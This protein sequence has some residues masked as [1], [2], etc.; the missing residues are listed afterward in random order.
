MQKEKSLVNA[1]VIKSNAYKKTSVKTAKGGDVIEPP[2]DIEELANLYTYNGFHQKCINLKAAITAGM[3][4]EIVSSGK[5]SI[6]KSDDEYRRLNSFI[7]NHITGTGVTFT[8]TLINF[9]TDYEIFGHAFLEVARNMKGEISSV[10]HLP[11]MDIRFI[12]KENHL[13]AVQLNDE[14]SVEFSP[15][16]K[17]KQGTNEYLMLKSYNPKNR[18]YGVPDY[19]GSA[20]GI[21]LDRYAAGYNIKRFE[22]NAIPE[23]IITIK[24]TVLSREA[25]EKIKQ[26]FTNNVKGF[27]NAG[28]SLILETEDENSSIEIKTLTSEIK[29]ASYRNLRMD[30]RDEIMAAHG[31]PK[32]LIGIAEPGGLGGANEGKTQLKV[33]QECLI[34]PRQRRLEF[35]LNEHLV[36]TGLG[37]TKYKL[38]LNRIYVDDPADDS[39]YYSE[40]VNAGI[41]NPDDARRELGYV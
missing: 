29:D 12:D 13:T 21:I 16:N 30:T 33:F 34:E 39:K 22:N 7:E 1:E 4:F 11:A 28:R 32:R 37:I 5:N 41:I 27:A 31:I 40:L 23:T 24:G 20:A 14:D 36:K 10:Y 25:K 26:F 35:L 9:Q 3:G 17:T 15:F 19:L 2:Y 6:N 8:E 38:Q 18:F